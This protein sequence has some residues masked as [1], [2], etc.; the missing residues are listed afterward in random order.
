M[1]TFDSVNFKMFCPSCGK[2][3][4]GWQTKQGPDAMLTLEPSDVDNFHSSCHGCGIWY[5][6]ERDS[7][8]LKLRNPP[9]TMAEVVDMGF[10]I[11]ASR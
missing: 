1:G 7:P 5:E 3:V 4:T 2:E 8:P 9:Y 11:K 10:S 6:F